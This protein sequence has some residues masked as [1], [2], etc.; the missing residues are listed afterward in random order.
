M[1]ECV[2]MDPRAHD[3]VD[4]ASV[5]VYCKDIAEAFDYRQDF[6]DAV[7]VELSGPRNDT[8]M[9]VVPWPPSPLPTTPE[10][11]EGT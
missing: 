11:G 10:E 4:D 3:D 9:T 8:T 7:L 6:P 1:S 5:Y 2:L